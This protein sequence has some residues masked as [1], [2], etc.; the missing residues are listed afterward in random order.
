MNF[1]LQ[2]VNY[3]KG[4]SRRIIWNKKTR[5]PM[6]IKSAGA[7]KS[8]ND[9]VYQL[10]EQMKGYETLTG[11]IR[12]IMIVYYPDNRHDLDDSLICDCLQKARVIE[13]DRQIVEKILFKRF[14]KNNPRIKVEVLELRNE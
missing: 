3:Q 13:N 4:N 1:L 6:V 14:D 10:K 12:L 9:F 2:G 7:L 5:R 11:F 8:T